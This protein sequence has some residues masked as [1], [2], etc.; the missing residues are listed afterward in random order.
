MAATASVITILIHYKSNEK[1]PKHYGY[2]SIEADLTGSTSFSDHTFDNRGGYNV[3]T[4]SASVPL[5]AL[6]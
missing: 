2:P 6:V 4:I 3:P 5:G 1:K